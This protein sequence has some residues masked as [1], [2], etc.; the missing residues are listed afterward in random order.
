[1]DEIKPLIK[2]K[3]CE[4][5]Y[6]KQT[7]HFRFSHDHEFRAGTQMN[8][9]AIELCS[10]SVVFLIELLLDEI[11]FEINDKDEEIKTIVTEKFEFEFGSKSVSTANFG[12]LRLS[13]L[14][15]QYQIDYLSNQIK[16]PFLA[17]LG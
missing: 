16:I 9:M 4:E 8:R 13:R 11:K 6:Q 3:N 14:W 15:I 12:A 2:E 7:A 17:T 10:N 5:K 1:M